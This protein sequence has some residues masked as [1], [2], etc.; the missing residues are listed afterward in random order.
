VGTYYYAVV[1][2]D[3]Y[4]NSSFSNNVNVTTFLPNIPVM[5]QI[6]PNP[7][8]P[9]NISL[10][11][12]N[13][14][15]ATNYYIFRANQPIE[16]TDGLNYI[17]NTTENL[18]N[19]SNFA[20]GTYYYTVIA[21]N[22][23]GNTSISNNVNV[24]VVV[25]IPMAPILNLIIPNPSPNGTICLSWN[26]IA[27][28][29]TYNV[30]QYNSFITNVNNSL[31]LINTTSSNSLIIVMLTNGTYYYVVTAVNTSGESNVNNCQNVIIAIPPSLTS[32][33]SSTISS[34]SNNFT[35]WI[36]GGAFL[37][38]AVVFTTLIILRKRIDR[39]V[40]SS[41]PEN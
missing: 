12:T 11:W 4:W 32:I 22:L 25:P 40:Q 38:G 26:M 21:S 13:T 19:D 39:S 30:Y 8:F 24:I 17:A 6:F 36:V 3:Q 5:S 27:G 16:T 18:Y 41:T 10:S 20:V 14:T 28:A 9:G 7:C 29:T 37:G 35:Y 2:S 34:K 33:I 23:F 1:A 15:G 31:I